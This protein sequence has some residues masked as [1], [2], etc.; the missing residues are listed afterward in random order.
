MAHILMHRPHLLNVPES[1]PLP[2]GYVLRLF[3]GDDLEYLASTL[4]AA[5]DEPW[6]RERVQTSLTETPD[7]KAVYVITWHGQP[8][9]TA[10]SRWLPDRFPQ[11]GY[12]HWVATHPQHVRK[13]LASALLAHLLHDFR[14]RG[15]TDA[16]LETDDFRIPA[17]R[18]YLKFGFLPVYTVGEEDHRYRWSSIFQTLFRA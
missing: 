18:S 5:F 7:V 1:S 11:S 17:I 9:A 14:D 15:Y 4:S 8:V 2:D 3:N 10:S 16:V 6:S 13:G 12:V